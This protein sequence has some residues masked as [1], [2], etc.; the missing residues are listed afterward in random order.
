MAVAVFD[1][2]TWSVLYPA[3]VARG[4]TQAYAT[5]LFNGPAA[6]L[7]NNTDCSPIVDIPTRTSLLYMVVAH[8]AFLEG[9]GSSGL[10]G[11]VSSAS[12]G[13]VSV[14]TDYGTQSASA[15]YWLQSPYGA[16]YWQASAPW[17]VFQYVAAPPS[18]AQLP[19]G[20][21]F[22]GYRQPGQW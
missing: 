2:A 3:L 21:Y 20:F 15:A 17:R 7:L 22:P 10:V 8:L 1:W 12:E 19:A 18:P 16:Q 9:P 4:V 14:A 6:L 11:R 5:A 13:S